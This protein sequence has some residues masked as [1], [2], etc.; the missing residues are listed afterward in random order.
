MGTASSTRAAS[1]V[2][3]I[4]HWLRPPVFEDEAKS[5]E[6]FLL[7]V[8]LWAM[9]LM[10]FPYV[11]G[12]VVQTPALV[13][14]ALRQAL[15]GEAAN[16]VLLGL[17]R[18]GHVRVACILEVCAL[19]TF[20]TVSAA[21]DAGVRGQAY[22]MGYPLVIVVAGVLLG[23][24][25]AVVTTGAALLVGY[26]MLWMTIAP[27]APSHTPRFTWIVSVVV[28]PVITTLQ[29]LSERTVRRALRRV[30]AALAD[31]QRAEEAVRESE[32]RF[33]I[34]ADASFEGI[35]IHEGGVIREVNQRFAEVFGYTDP[36]ELIGKN[37]FQVLL[38]QESIALLHSH[39]AAVSRG[40]EVVGLR[41]DGSTF[42]GETQ[43]REIEYQ[44]RALRVV[45]MRDITERKRAESERTMLEKQLA[46]ALRL[47]SVGR[48][49]AGV[50]H[51][52][53][54]LLTCVMFNT[55][56]VLRRLPRG[57]PSCTVLEEVVQA[58]EKAAQLTRQLLEVGR[59]E[60][61]RP[62]WLNPNDV[63]EG[64]KTML[65]R[66]VGE[67]VRLEAVLASP[68]PAV[69]IDP[70]QLERVLVNLCV[71]ARDAMPDGGRIELRTEEA[72]LTEDEARSLV[73]ASPGKF[74]RISV[75]DTGT[76]MPKQVLDRVFE[77]F[78]TT[79]QP[80][81]G[82]GLGLASV[83]GIVKQNRGFV[84]VESEV[85][86]GTRFLVYLQ[87]ALD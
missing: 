51:D 37:G 20:M 71:N 85:G 82:T 2:G 64:I 52:F 32:R 63:I 65:A 8:V 36:G 48:L 42:R 24:R 80:G 10:P 70:G 69:L 58:S 35:M 68:L 75:S 47:E 74:V 23:A 44:G 84:R 38:S 49:A 4:P 34:L 54:N 55:S 25:G 72:R 1:R 53:N 59:Q 86:V 76:G 57:D 12:A 28:F 40:V 46:Q 83:H 33:R 39:D 79:K 3:W 56:I 61:A 66:M 6:A 26:S 67:Q 41:K 81:R 78:F 43:C 15:A 77:P 5:H 7:H 50:A 45:A 31:T 19:F 87:R 16:V 14:R 11:V 18:R 13:P 17:L 29:Y 22:Q 21:T 60:L 9:V 62:V 73:D 27:V 30:T